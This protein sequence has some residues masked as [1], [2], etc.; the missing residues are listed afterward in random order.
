MHVAVHR[1]LETVQ[2][3][4]EHD[5]V[6]VTALRDPVVEALGYDARSEYVE[7]YWLAVLGP[8]CV[9]AARRLNAWLEPESEGF[10]VPLAEFARSLG[11]GAGTAR[12]APVVRTLARLVDFGIAR[13]RCQLRVTNDIPTADCPPGGAPAGTPRRSARSVGTGAA[14]DALIETR[15]VGRGSRS[16]RAGEG[17]NSARPSPVLP[18]CCRRTAPTTSSLKGDTMQMQTIMLIGTRGGSG[19]STVA[20]ALAVFCAGHAPT[21]LVSNEPSAV[22]TLL[23]LASHV[24]EDTPRDVTPDLRLL[25]RPADSARVTV[26]DGGHTPTGGRSGD[27]TLAVLRGPCYLGLHTLARR[28]LAAL[29]GIVLVAEAKRALTRRD[30]ADVCGV[31]VV[32]TVLATDAIARTIDAGVLL[33]RLYHLTEFRDLR[34][35]ANDLVVTHDDNARPRAN[36]LPAP[37]R[38][39]HE[40]GLKS[41]TDLPVALS[42]TGRALATSSRQVCQRA[43]FLF[44]SHRL[45]RGRAEH[46]KAE[47]G[48]GRVLHRRGCNLGGG[49]LQRPR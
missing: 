29:D 41:V 1:S 15:S 13:R 7:T 3:V 27:L 2:W 9:L 34:R 36:P 25:E 26:V 24:D 42:A 40:T 37:Q 20:A 16:D 43:P 17:R 12:H 22:A 39:R 30:V 21:D 46:R 47:S 18:G 32:A 31:P 10:T 11:L 33:S 6:P 23:G 38:S 49:L 45:G 28:S 4:V 44:R 14:E 48:S 5:P 8:S 35:Y 19:T